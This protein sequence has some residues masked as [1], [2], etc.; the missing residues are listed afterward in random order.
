MIRKWSWAKGIFSTLTKLSLAKGIRSKTGA[1]IQKI[2]GGKQKQGIIILR[3]IMLI[4][5]YMQTNTYAW[6]ELKT[7]KKCVFCYVNLTNQLSFKTNFQTRATL[8]AEIPS[9]A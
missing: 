4:Y 6:R 9:A 2:F 8:N 3:D 7:M 5:T 1:P